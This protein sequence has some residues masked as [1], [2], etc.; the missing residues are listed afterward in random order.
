MK[1]TVTA[2]QSVIVTVDP[3]KFTK[4][5]M[6]EFRESFYNFHTIEEH[7]RHLGQLAIRGIAGNGAFIEGYGEADD[8]GIR[9]TF[10]EMIDLETSVVK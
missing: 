2:Q 1:Y 7:V 6:Q 5:F 10:P 8:M 4:K 9:F 3:K